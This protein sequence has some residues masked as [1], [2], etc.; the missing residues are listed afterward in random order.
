[1]GTTAENLLEQVLATQ[2]R[3]EAMVDELLAFTRATEKAVEPFL[4][5]R[6]RTWL[7]LLAKSRGART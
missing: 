3:L 7:A 1:M 5:G 4:T 2:A 6:G